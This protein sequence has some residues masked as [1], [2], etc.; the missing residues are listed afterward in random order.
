MSVTNLQVEA[1]TIAGVAGFQVQ[2]LHRAC[3]DSLWEPLAH[4]A[5]FRDRA[6]A[7]R[8]LAKVRSKP[9]WEWNWAHWGAPHDARITDIDAFKSTVAPYTVL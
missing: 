8:F 9:S 4:E 5:I 7:E 2:G 6:R 1:V 3:S